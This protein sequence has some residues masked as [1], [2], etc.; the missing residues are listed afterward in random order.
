MNLDARRSSHPIQHPVTNETEAMAAFDGITY[1][2]GQALIRMLEHYLGETA[3]RAGIRKYMADHAYGNTTTADMWHALE[4]SSDKPVAAIAASFTVQPGVPLIVAEATCVGEEQR[5]RLRQDRFTVGDPTPPAQRWPVPISLGPPQA[6]QG[7]GAVLLDGREEIAAG[8]CGDA[9]KLNLG[10][11]GYYRVQYD[12]VSRAALV[13]SASLMAPADRVNLLAD[14][15]AMVEAARAEPQSYFELVEQFA[16][17]DSRAVWE[18][19]IQSLTRLDHLARNREERAAIQSYARAKLRPA[20]ARLGWDSRA[21]ERDD[22]ALLRARL[23]RILGEL[24]EPP[25]VTEAKRRFAAFLENAAALPPALRDAVTHVVGVSADRDGYA[26]LLALAR[27]TTSTN[28]RARYYSAA[29]S[30]RDPSLARATLELTLTEELPNSLVGSVI[31]AVAAAGEQPN[32]VWTFLQHNF[33]ALSSKQ[34]PS[35]THYFVSN[36]M[37]NFSDAER[38]AELA[39]FAP[40]HATSGGRIV[41]ARAEDS[42]MIA[43]EFKARALPAIATWIRERRERP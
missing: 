42:I 17:D 35:F 5:V 4:A 33:T 16:D 41:A 28:E 1:S 40:V 27:K 15:W 34:G 37:T 12:S 13:K 23:I 19:I 32:L 31:N 22:D 3:F 38:A 43:A 25:V 39:S 20:F 9:F 30:A 6:A 10:D 11:I 24:G 14:S 8:R 36:F 21:G 26:T 18:H 29:A 2:K 7:A